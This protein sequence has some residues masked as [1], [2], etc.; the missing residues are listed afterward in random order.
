MLARIELSNVL[1]S[2]AR[3]GGCDSMAVAS[4]DGMLE[5]T[6]SSSCLRLVGCCLEARDASGAGVTGAA[7]AVAGGASSTGEYGRGVDGR[8]RV[9]ESSSGTHCRS[10]VRRVT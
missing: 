7:L 10:S 3:F 5:K 4:G 2:R 1:A 9:G 6:Y 8:L